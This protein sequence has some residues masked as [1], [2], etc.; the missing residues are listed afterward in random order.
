MVPVR[1]PELFTAAKVMVPFPDA[2]REWLQR[3]NRRHDEDGVQFYGQQQSRVDPHKIRSLGRHL[4][5]HRR[6]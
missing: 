6:W 1:E 2:H 5:P 4:E 3:I